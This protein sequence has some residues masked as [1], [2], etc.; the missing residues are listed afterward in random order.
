MTDL[1]PVIFAR[2]QNESID[3][4]LAPPDV[5]RIA[6]NVRWRKDGRPAKRFGLTALTT[7]G[8][9]AGLGYASQ[10]VN[11]I[12][13]W[14]TT[15]V[16]ALGSGVRTLCNGAWSPIRYSGFGELAHW[17]PGERNIIAR[18]ERSVLR[19]VTSGVCGGYVVNAWD[20]NTQL[21]FSVTLASDGSTVIPPAAVAGGTYPRIVGTTNFLYIIYRSGTNINLFTFDPATLGLSA[22]ASPGT[23]NTSGSLLDACA[24]GTDFVLAYQ[25]AASTITVKL[26]S[27]IAAP[28]VTQSQNASLGHN[29]VALIGVVSD[30]TNSV[31][32][33]TLDNSA[34]LNAFVWNNALTAITGIS[35]IETDT[36][37]NSQPGLVLLSAGICR[38][39]WGGNVAATETGYTRTAAIDTAGAIIGG[40]STYFG[41]NHASK[42]FLGP[43]NSATAEDGAYVWVHTHNSTQEAGG[44]RKWDTQRTY[45]LMQVGGV[46][47]RRQMHTPNVVASAPATFQHLSDVVS[48]GFGAG[49]LVPLP[50]AI[51]F[52]NGF[53][54][55]YGFDSVTFHSIFENQRY[56]A[57]DTA[58]AGRALQFTGGSLYELNGFAE[59]TGFS[60]FPVV[61]SVTGGGG[62]AMP[63]ATDYL[64][65]AVYEYLDLQGRRHRSAPSDPFAYNSGANTSAT[66]VM[67]PLIA[68][69]HF[70]GGAVSLHV[71][72]T[73]GG[74]GTYH[75][76]TP[77]T[78]A[79]LGGTPAGA[80]SVATVSF[81]DTMSDTTA[82]GQEFIYTD[83]GVADNTLAPPSTFA[84]VCAGRVWLGGQL[85]RNV[86]TASK[87]LAEGEPTQFSDLDAFSVFLPQKC[88]GIASLDGTVVAFARERIY[89]IQGEGP[90]D[91]GVGQFSPPGELPTDVGCVD[92]RSVVETSIGIFFQSKRGI[93]LLPRGFNTPAFVGA[94][95][96]DTLRAYPIV[97][98]AT[99]VSSQANQGQ[100]TLGEITVRF[101]VATDEAAQ[102]PT[103]TKVL[104][105]DVRTGGWSVDVAFTANAYS[106]CGTWNDTF[107]VPKTSIGLAS[108]ASISVED[109]ATFAEDATFIQTQLGTGDIRPFGVGGYGQF[110]KVLLLG[111]YRGNASLLVSVSVDGADADTYTFA[112]T[113][114]DAP[115]RSVYLDIT[116]KI[117]K[118]CSI[119]V[120][121]IDAN[122]APTEGFIMQA[123]FI[124]SELIG[125]TKRLPVGRKA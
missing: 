75:R 54:A 14:N 111:E 8:L 68:D 66:L 18:D 62:G 83:G 100:A 9:D 76:V 1:L 122:G 45:Y 15:P 42:P 59:E 73:L 123:L 63:A 74:Q 43:A 84:T 106:L 5:H 7:T 110:N 65:R 85:D 93:F 48:L 103:A 60:N 20:D 41:A 47:L 102:S 37:N 116:P 30:S 124:E 46:T 11:A 69:T 117:Q 27:A 70:P 72:R 40:I 86:V 36:N 105:Y 6:Q 92:W 61:E 78:G 91:Q 81:A 79:P 107:V 2:G 90:N 98:S 17:G 87:L 3:P 67:K 101:V 16:L 19:N 64:Y 49:H 104:V 89:L 29:G 97:L 50:N 113:S 44:N 26:L 96:E 99:L 77:A 24:R 22:V 25:S 55:A 12:D 53:A 88:T 109:P 56:A 21:Y 80:I 13:T 71:Y 119:S 33:S 57:R 32:L 38:V 28:V 52:G 58:K 125:K 23:L 120:N 34:V 108:L 94:E 31:F 4:R 121:V 114:S 95:V 35:V 118:G 82:G 115:D 10:N 51:R 39:V 112:V